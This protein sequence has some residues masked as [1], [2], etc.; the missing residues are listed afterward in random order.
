MLINH[1]SLL[2]MC[3]GQIAHKLL[4]F[5]LLTTNL[6]L[7]PVA[8]LCRRSITDRVYRQSS[9]DDD[10]TGAQE[11]AAAEKASTQL[12][13]VHLALIKGV[14]GGKAAPLHLLSAADTSVAEALFADVAT[15]RLWLSEEEEDVPELAAWRQRWCQP[16]LL[17][18]VLAKRTMTLQ[19]VSCCLC[20][21]LDRRAAGADAW[22]CV[23]PVCLQALDL[24]SLLE[25]MLRWDPAARPTAAQLLQ[26]PYFEPLKVDDGKRKQ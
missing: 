3:A 10:D 24:V 2:D 22:C 26:Q 12:D 21:V 13:E 9:D 17:E 5:L 16:S 4:F 18:R 11:A 6:W 1:H 14:T 15:G 25:P 19:Q 8:T 23:F 20:F 7:C